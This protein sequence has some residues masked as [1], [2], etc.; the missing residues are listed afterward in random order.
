MVTVQNS[1]LSGE[2]RTARQ[3][4]FKA[5]PRLALASVGPV[6][7][8][9]P[10]TLGRGLWDSEWSTLIYVPTPGGGLGGRAAFQ[11]MTKKFLETMMT[12][13]KYR[14]FLGGN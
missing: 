11:K 1:Q 5:W 2:E 14:P 9:E 12:S 3:H 4:L 10:F 8:S 13:R 6:S 7:I